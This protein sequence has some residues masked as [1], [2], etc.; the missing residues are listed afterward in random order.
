MKI[1][2]KITKIGLEL[3]SFI[4]GG[5]FFNAVDA[6]VFS[7]TAITAFAVFKTGL[8]LVLYFTMRELIAYME[9]EWNKIDAEIKA[10][11]TLK[12]SKKKSK[13][14]KKKKSKTGSFKKER[15]RDVLRATK[16]L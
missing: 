9:V 16:K 3:F 14:S 4:A 13:K 11:K 12:T 2:F 15:I 10:S 8:F 1:F 7:G 5:M 6:L